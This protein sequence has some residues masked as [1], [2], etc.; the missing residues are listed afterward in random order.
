MRKSL[1][2]LG[3]TLIELV[4][5]IVIM[6]VIGGMVSVFMKSPIDAY[7][8]SARRAALT[9][10]ADTTLRRLSRDLRKALPNSVRT[11]NAQCLEFIPT[12]SGG[13]YRADN[14]AAG[15]DFNANDTSFNMLGSNSA[16]PVDQRIVTG[17]V[18]VVYNLGVAGAD[19]YNGNNTAS[20]T[21]NPTEAGTPVESTIAI[22]STRFPLESG[23]KRFH[24]VPATERVVSYVCSGSNLYRTVNSTNFVSACPTGG[25][26]MARN[27]SACSF[28]YGGS[29]LQRNGV[30]RLNLQLTDD[31]ETVSLQN[32]INVNNTP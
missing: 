13:R 12:K 15:L 18:I 10:V 21:G 2:Q 1:R 19:A 29:D 24:V 31:G 26:I 27:V 4:M 11:P 30:I 20:V 17:D 14:T 25:A 22:G 23:A 9:D 6:G 32:A 28:D 7:F 16:L 8:A 5:V 3:F